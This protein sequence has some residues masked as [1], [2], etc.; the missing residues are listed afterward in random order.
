MTG[1]PVLGYGCTPQ[2]HQIER[3]R[4]VKTSLTARNLELTNRLRTDIERK[5]R[6]L[7]RTTH[8]GAEVEIELIAQVR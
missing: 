7:D 2:L 6:R 1:R 3:H 4:I 8:D 5:L